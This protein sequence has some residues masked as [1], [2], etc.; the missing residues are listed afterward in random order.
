MFF[1]RLSCKKVFF[2]GKN[3]PKK[4]GSFTAYVRRDGKVTVPKSV[5][6]SLGIEEDDL[7]ECKISKVKSGRTRARTKS[8]ENSAHLSEAKEAIE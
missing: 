2:G 7:V 8:H 1:R 3:L 4:E 6:D 5:R